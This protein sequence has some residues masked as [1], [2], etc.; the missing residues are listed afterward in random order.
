MN[1]QQAL[2]QAIQQELQHYP[3][4][5]GTS[6]TGIIMIRHDH[7]GQARH[8]TIDITDINHTQLSGWHHGPTYLT[9]RFPQQTI[10]LQDP[11][12]FNHIHHYINTHIPWNTTSNKPSS[13]NTHNNS[14]TPTHTY[15]SPPSKK[16]K[17]TPPPATDPATTP[18]TKKTN[19]N[20]PTATPTS[21]PTSP[22]KSNNTYAHR[23]PTQRPLPPHHPT[24]AHQTR[25]PTNPTRNNPPL[26]HRHQSPTN[27]RSQPPLR[28][29]I[30]PGH[31]RTTH[32]PP[33]PHHPPRTQPRT[34]THHPLARTTMEKPR[35]EKTPPH[36]NRRRRRRQ[37]PQ[38]KPTRVNTPHG[39]PNT[40]KE[41]TRM[42]LCPTCYAE[43]CP[44]KG[45][46]AVSD[47]HLEAYK[48]A[49][50]MSPPPAPA[51]PAEVRPPFLSWWWKGSR[52]GLWIN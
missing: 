13:T 24:L 31:P 52:Y 30:H 7:Q 28:H 37:I 43:T 17:N 48:R 36:I 41:Q 25:N 15:K 8:I 22:T 50:A 49:A 19:N 1:I 2:Q 42:Q 3:A 16:D 5:T 27:R 21:S 9:A 23:P 45:G 33:R 46:R 26:P 44:C 18:P 11:N 34:K 51:R 32:R 14:N 38:V 20:T 39:P 35:L 10:Q 4:R 40:Q 12:Y 29:P 47:P 6:G